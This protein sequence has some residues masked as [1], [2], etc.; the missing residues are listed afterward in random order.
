MKWEQDLPSPGESS[1]LFINTQLS[2]KGPFSRVLLPRVLPGT[3]TW[4][5]RAK[6]LA[7]HQLCLFFSL[8]FSIIWVWGFISFV[9]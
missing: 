7:P 1:V 8:F 9:F 4:C 2:L 3:L 6:W 5:V